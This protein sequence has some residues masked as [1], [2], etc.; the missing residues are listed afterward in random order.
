M[1][2]DVVAL[3]LDDRIPA[4]RL[5]ALLLAARKRR[6][7]K[8]RRAAAEAGI[9][10]TCLRDYER[11][12][13]PVP[14][15]VCARL[16]QAYGDDLTAHVPLRMPVRID[17]GY[18]VVDHDAQP[19]AGAGGER[20][21][22][23]SYTELLRRLRTVRPGQPVPLRACDLAALSTALGTDS[24][25]IELQIVELLG[26]SR[27]EAAALR[28]ELLRRKVILPVAGLAAGIAMLTGAQWHPAAHSDAPDQPPVPVATVESLPET[29]LIAEHAVAPV[30]DL[31]APPPIEIAP[32]ATADPAPAPE[33]LPAPT[34][35]VEAPEELA[36]PVDPGVSIPEGEIESIIEIGDP[37]WAGDG[38]P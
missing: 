3:L 19:V 9:S 29:T 38:P 27:D 5:G 17:D 13:E 16:A 14:A 8:R 28:I 4:A 15:E 6:G 7:W 21:V 26:C 35:A 1:T 33:G 36:P 23:E 10:I 31:P 2:D 34:A 20:A 22:L 24:N 18:L 30:V 25:E 32:P 12:L 11:G 37:D